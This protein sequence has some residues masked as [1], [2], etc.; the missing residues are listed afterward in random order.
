[1]KNIYEILKTLK[2]WNKTN[3]AL[4]MENGKKYFI[5][6]NKTSIFPSGK[7]R[8]SVKHFVCPLHSEFMFHVI[9]INFDDIKNN[10]M[11][12]TK[13]CNNTAHG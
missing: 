11:Y 5:V 4:K 8:K 12:V 6:P 9:Q 1:M 2:P 10:K 13:I 3:I 7:Q